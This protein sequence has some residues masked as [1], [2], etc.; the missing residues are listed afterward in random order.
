MKQTNKTTIGIISTIL[1]GTCWGF[2]GTCGQYLFDYKNVDPGWLVMVRMMCAGI[3]L[4]ALCAIRKEPGMFS[5]WKDKKALG[6]LALFS[7]AG[8]WVSQFTYLTAI[9][10]SNA[11]TTT[12]L[13][14]LNTVMI[15]LTVCVLYKKLPVKKEVLCVFLALLGTFLIATHGNL[16]ALSISKEG[17]FWGLL[18][19]VGA[20]FYSMAPGNLMDRYG[21]LVVIGY[22]M[23]F[24]GILYTIGSGKYRINVQPDKGML[25]ALIAIV[26]LGTICSYAL[27][28]KGVQLIGPV[29]ASVLALTEPI[30]AT[31]FSFLWLKTSFAPI[32]LLG[33]LLILSTVVIL[34][35]K[36]KSA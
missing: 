16:T 11:G 19:A 29:K 13:Q 36:K 15:M 18:S 32:D 23:L 7:I 33:F 26:L 34:S 2:S 1:G 12:V 8:L 4:I 6:R 28:L 3:L 35:M 31:I 27:Y 9:S 22:A 10:Y 24:A 20:A 25:F 5:I 30:S 21:N 14:S 17:L